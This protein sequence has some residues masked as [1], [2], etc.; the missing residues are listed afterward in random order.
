VKT[1]V[2]SVGEGKSAK[3]IKLV[4]SIG[5]IVVFQKRWLED[6]YIMLG[7]ARFQKEGNGGSLGALRD[8]ICRGEG[9]ERVRDNKRKMR[10]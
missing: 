9:E 3:K 4:V 6:A 1:R 7:G 8:T 2:I 5:M 10:G